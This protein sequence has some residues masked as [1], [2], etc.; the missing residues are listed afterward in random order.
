MWGNFERSQQNE[1]TY[2]QGIESSP[3]AGGE[4]ADIGSPVKDPEWVVPE[5]SGITRT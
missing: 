1:P 2:F 5:C 4:G 3:P